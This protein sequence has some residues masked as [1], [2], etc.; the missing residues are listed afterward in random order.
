[1]I[2]VFLPGGIGNQMFQYAA[3]RYLAEN[4]NTALCLDTSWYHYPIKRKFELNKFMINASV[5]KSLISFLTFN[6]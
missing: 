6:L 1:M 2:R 3:G 5:E 4:H